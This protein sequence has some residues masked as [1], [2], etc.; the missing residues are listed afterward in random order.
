MKHLLII[1]S[2]L[3]LSS[4]VIGQS[5][6]PQTIIVPTGSLGDI[7]EVRKKMLEKTLESKLDDY[8]DIV[9]K[10]LFEEA[11]EQAFQEMDSDEC[12]EEQCIMMIREILQ[13]ENSFQMVLMEEEGDT[14]ISLTWND[15]DKKRVEEEYCEGCKTKQLRKMIE[16]LVEKLVGVKKVEPEPVVVQDIPKQVEPKVVEKKV[17]IPKIEPKV[18]EEKV[19]IPKVEPVVVETPKVIPK[20]VAKKKIANLKKLLDTKICALCDLSKVNL[21]GENLKGANLYKANLSDADLKGADLNGANLS[22]ANLSF[23]NLSK[24]NLSFANLKGADLR[25]ANLKGVNLKGAILTKVNLSYAKLSKANLKGVNLSGADL[26]YAN[27]SDANLSD[28]IIK[29]AKLSKA[30]LEGA[31]MER[32]IED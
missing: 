3:L 16:G 22:K 32:V 1:L 7:S 2:L 10:E 5:E 27:L 6:K 23:A 25:Y 13:V 21:S 30:I 29:G 19:I 28:A 15:L 31:I 12:T 11:Q 20:K 24:A 8:F 4:P 14:Q 17:T 18:V 9:P 26:F